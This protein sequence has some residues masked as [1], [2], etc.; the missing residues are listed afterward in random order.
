MIG[1]IKKIAICIPTYNRPEV[2]LDTC[3]EIIKT[4]DDDLYD[5]Y[6]YDSSTDNETEITLRGIE[7]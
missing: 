3:L 4:L 7:K 2:I 1:L 5:L 6:I